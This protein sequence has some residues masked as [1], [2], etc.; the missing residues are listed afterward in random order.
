M[1]LPN[2]VFQEVAQEF[3]CP[4]IKEGF[5][6]RAYHSNGSLVSRNNP[7]GVMK[8]TAQV[9]EQVGNIMKVNV[10][11]IEGQSIALDVDSICF[12][13]DTDNAIALL[14]ACHSTYVL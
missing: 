3:N 8:D 6:D 10:I 4:Y 9:V 7:N 5:A 11:S 12:H 1:G 13:G 2:S 14:K